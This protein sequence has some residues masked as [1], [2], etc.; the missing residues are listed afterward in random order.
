[1]TTEI[2]KVSNWYFIAFDSIL[3]DDS[4]NNFPVGGEFIALSDGDM[5]V[6]V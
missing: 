2:T 4:N 6:M 1:M 3:N 5:M